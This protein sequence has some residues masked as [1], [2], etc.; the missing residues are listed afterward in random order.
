MSQIT[1]CPHCATTFKVVTDQLRISEGWVRCGQ[2]KEVFDAHEHMV[3]EVP[4]MALLPEM[5]LEE[6]QTPPWHAGAPA[7]RNTQAAKVW[8][9]ARQA[10]APEM[11]AVPAAPENQEASPATEPAGGVPHPAV[12]A[13]LLAEPASEAAREPVPEPWPESPGYELPAPEPL[14]PEPLDFEPLAGE[15]PAPVVAAPASEPSVSEQ[16]VED[17]ALPGDAPVPDSAWPQETGDAA[18]PQAPQAA[19]ERID[20]EPVAPDAA[21][22]DGAAEEAPPP[23]A[24]VTEDMPAD[25]PADDVSVDAP[26]EAPE[27]ASVEAAGAHAE[28]AAQAAPP[29]EPGFVKAAR[30]N[31][32]W[33]RPVVRGVL[34]LAVVALLLALALQVAVQRR[35]TI[36]AQYPPARPW[37]ETLC[38]PLHCTLQAPRHIAAVVIDSSSFIKARN[39]ASAY[40]LRMSLKNTAQMTVATPA[41]ELTLTDAQDQVVLRRVLLPEELA[42]PAELAPG[43]VWGG[44]LSLQVIQGAAQ[45][46]GY[47]LLAFY[48]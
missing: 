39:D 38:Q 44:A 6:L 42:A 27:E 40:Q 31:A 18:L 13:F 45:V 16:D 2:C 37:L 11:P 9:S 24:K 33:R 5:P 22:A 8:S 10:R 36:A 35:D 46:A 20:P 32:F 30:R 41:L 23:S 21:L 48:P 28:E 1:R 4:A 47:R 34:V 3:A 29:A 17:R 7:S 25:M 19:P 15:P 26:E 12:P 14:V 43:L